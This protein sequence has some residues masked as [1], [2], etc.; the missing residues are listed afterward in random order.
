MPATILLVDDESELAINCERLLRPLGHRCL[1]ASDGLDAIAL[2]ART[3]LDLVVTDLRLPGADG[4]AVARYARGRRPPVPV[5]LITAYDSPWARKIAGEVCVSAFLLKPFTNS[6]FLDA[7]RRVL[8]AK[9][10][11]ADD[12]P[13]S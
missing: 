8:A 3:G 7:V 10:E 4:F 5:I 13:A 6:A 12:S 9:S 1:R 2:I 11:R